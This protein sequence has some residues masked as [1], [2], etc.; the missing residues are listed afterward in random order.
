MTISALREGIADQ[1]YNKFEGIVNNITKKE[2]K[3][4]ALQLLRTV[5]LEEVQKKLRLQVSED[6]AHLTL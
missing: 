6:W 4:D 3:A 5:I 2:R 1:I